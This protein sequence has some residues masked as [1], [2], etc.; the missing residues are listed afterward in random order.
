MTLDEIKKEIESND[1]VLFMKGTPTFPQCGFSAHVTSILAAEG[2]SF[3]SHDVLD[4]EELRVNI[5]EFS[6][7]PTI[8]Q[9]Y[10]RGE[11]IGGADIAH[12]M[13]DSGELSRVLQPQGYGF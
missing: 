8:P 12:E 3:V 2:L 6:D 9:L 10:V 11:F 7:W 5:K 4:D 13:Y 1:I